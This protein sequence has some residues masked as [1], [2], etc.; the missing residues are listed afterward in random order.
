MKLLITGIAGFIGSHVAKVA[1]SRGWEV[2]GIVRDTTDLWRL[3]NIQGDLSLIRCELDNLT[4]LKDVLS[5]KSFDACIHCAWFATPGKYLSAIENITSLN[6]CLHLVEILAAQGCQ[7]FVG[8]GSCFEYNCSWGYLSEETPT[9]P[10]SLYAAAKS[11]AQTALGPLGAKLG[12]KT[13][14]A[15]LFLQYGPEED[16]RRLVPSVICSLLKG[17]PVKTTP[18]EQIRDFLHIYDVAT[19]LLE[20]TTNDLS[21]T[22]N[23]GSGH[24]VTVRRVVETIALQLGR[25]DLPQFGALDYRA[26]DPMFICANNTRLKSYT[27]WKPQYTLSAGLTQT[28]DWWINQRS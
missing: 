9:V 13:A 16:N 26:G 11:A 10:S 3:K 12:V 5:G 2:T 24:P 25:P 23:I 14:W 4:R 1:L 27:A 19:A 7:R 20:V 17:E 21:G 22:V 8:V 18:G 6:S 15:R 28:I